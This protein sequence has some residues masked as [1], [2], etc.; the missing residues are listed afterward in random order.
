MSAT[1]PGVSRE[2]SCDG[3]RRYKSHGAK[4]ALR[5]LKARGEVGLQ[6][7]RCAHCGWFHLGHDPRKERRAS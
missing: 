1:I 6:K 3:K 7:Y 2:F 4:Q 5:G